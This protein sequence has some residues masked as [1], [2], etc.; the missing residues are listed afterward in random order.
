[1]SKDAMA[2]PL[3]F[4]LFVRTP[5]EIVLQL[6]ANLESTRVHLGGEAERHDRATK[7]AFSDLGGHPC[8]VLGQNLYRNGLYSLNFNDFKG[9][10][11][12]I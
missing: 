11:K 6:E 8:P 7:G 1:M 3:S 9:E 12:K 10:L 5:S 2:L 4:E